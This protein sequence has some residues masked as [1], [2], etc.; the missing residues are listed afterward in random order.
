MPS[1]LAE[2]VLSKSFSTDA[3]AGLYPWRVRRLPA[4]ALGPLPLLTVETD[5]NPFPQLTWARLEAFSL[6][7]MRLH[8]A[9]KDARTGRTGR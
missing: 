2:S 4:Q 5:G 3:L 9:M 6:Q 8:E 1:R 7:A